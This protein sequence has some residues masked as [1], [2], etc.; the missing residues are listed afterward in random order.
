MTMVTETR[1]WPAL[2]W[3]IGVVSAV[4]MLAVSAAAW[5]HVSGRMAMH[6]TSTGTDR[7]ASKSEG[8]LAMPITVLLGTVLV[9]GALRYER[10]RRP[11]RKAGPAVAL[12]WLGTAT[13]LTGVHISLVVMAL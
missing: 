13:L 8:L 12:I 9:I 2:L 6:F 7:Y 4:V 11:N 1:N 5:S 3:R 10:W